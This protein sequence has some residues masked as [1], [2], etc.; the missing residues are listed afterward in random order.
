MLL[1]V[2]AALREHAESQENDGQAGP[3]CLDKAV[4]ALDAR[5]ENVT[6][7]LAIATFAMAEN[8]IKTNSIG[9]QC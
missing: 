2:F 8:H 4:V 5:Y 7:R 3:P 1:N 9:L 6:A